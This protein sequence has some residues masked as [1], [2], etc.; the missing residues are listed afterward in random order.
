MSFSNRL[1]ERR[2]YL[3]MTRAELAEKLGVTPAA[4]G[5]YENG[6]SSPKEE[7]L[8]KIFDVLSVEPNYLWQDEMKCSSV[9]FEVSY[10]ERDHIKKYRALDEHGKDIIDTIIDKEYARC[11]AP[12]PEAEQDDNCI[13]LPLSEQPASAGT[14]TYLG[15][16]AFT[17]IKVIAN[18]K[19]RRADFCV[20]VQGDSMEPIYFDG[21]IVMISKERPGYS[22][23]GLVT[24]DGCGYIKRLGMGVLESENKKYAPIPLDESVVVNGRAVGLLQPDW[25]IR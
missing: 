2:E 25:I 14:G 18:D 5:N 4:I 1:K 19:T 21:D 23:I 22:G 9:K 10:S 11:T 6:V 16:E 12:E 17:P 3:K 24:L 13:Y 8:Y 7:I 20:R 15:P